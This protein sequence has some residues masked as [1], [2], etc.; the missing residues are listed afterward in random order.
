MRPSRGDESHPPVREIG[1]QDVSHR[2]ERDTHWIAEAGG[3]ATAA[4]AGETRTGTAGHGVDVRR[5]HRLAV[6]R[7]RG[8]GDEPDA[9]VAR[10]GDGEITQ[11]VGSHPLRVTQ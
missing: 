7:P 5:G 4:V 3:R 2:V 6:V 8:G 11:G 9:V 10:V 1:Y